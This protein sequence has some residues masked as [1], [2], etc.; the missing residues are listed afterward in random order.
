MSYL[1]YMRI[2]KYPFWVVTRSVNKI[3]IEE[4]ISS[5]QGVH[6]GLKDAVKSREMSGT[7]QFIYCTCLI[8]FQISYW[9][10]WSGHGLT[11]SYSL[12][13]RDNWFHCTSL[14]IISLSSQMSWSNSDKFLLVQ[15]SQKF[16]R[17]ASTKQCFVTYI[18][19]SYSHTILDKAIN[20]LY[21]LCLDQFLLYITPQECRVCNNHMVY[22]KFNHI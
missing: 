20:I 1:W 18:V 3:A 17:Y 7:F 15:V 11:G 10:N 19:Y 6:Q 2:Q 8:N 13:K 21:N 5:D 16:L 4:C 9:Q 22:N 12:A 14:I